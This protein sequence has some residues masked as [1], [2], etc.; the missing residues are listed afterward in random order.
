MYDFACPI[1][2]SLE[3]VTHALRS[4]EYHD[5]NPLYGWVIEILKLRVVLVEDFSR[6]NFGHVFL[7]KRKLQK[8][9]DTGIVEGWNDPRFPTVQGVLRRGLAV[10][11]LTEFIISIG[12]S[13]SIVMMEMEKLWVMNKKY[14]DPIVPRHTAIDVQDRVPVTFSNGPAQVE[15]KEGPKHKKKCGPWK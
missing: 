11:A 3:G 1:V 4:S 2:D 10:P 9:V 8:L 12:A 6:L 5:R 15:A 13:K 7:S 14:L